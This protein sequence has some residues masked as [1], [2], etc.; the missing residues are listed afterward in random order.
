MTTY[1]YAARTKEGARVR[2]TVAAA[3]A[4]DV[5]QMLRAR[6]LYVTD[7][8]ASIDAPFA[9]RLPSAQPRRAVVVAFYRSLAIMVRSGVALRRALVVSIERTN[10]R[11]FGETLRAVLADIESGERLSAALGRRPD[12]FEPL[13]IAMITAGE[14]GGVLDIILDRLA[15][16]VETSRTMQRKI[17]GALTYPAFILATAAAVLVLVVV[18]LLPAF[19]PV[20]ASLDVP[21]PPITRMLLA[22]GHLARAP[23]AV[24]AI[25]LASGVTI[26]TSLVAIRQPRLR[27]MLDELRF[28]I[29]LVG[30]LARKSIASRIARTLGTLLRSGVGVLQA[31]D[32]L[33]PVAGSERYAR[34]LVAVRARVSDGTSLGDALRTGGGFDPIFCAMVAVGE[35]TGAVDEMLV[36][37]ADYY[38]DDVTFTIADLHA[39]LEPALLVVLGIAIGTLVYAIFVPLYGLNVELHRRR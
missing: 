22:L 11:R 33:A 30:P 26:V 2:G 39:I 31:L 7:V 29:P 32:V 8:T 17:R 23:L 4:S 6:S 15:T 20:Y 12:C 18:K 38:D 28:R 1:R 9:L 14:L 10:D 21:V 34:L 36:T 13:A 5:V 19:E 27:S 25:V 16:L 24:A 3:G 37:L 35:E